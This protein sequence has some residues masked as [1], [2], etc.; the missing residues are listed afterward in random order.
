MG[1]FVEDPASDI[2]RSAMMP[3]QSSLNASTNFMEKSLGCH[4]GENGVGY[5][6]LKS[7]EADDGLGEVGN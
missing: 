4:P 2:F 1:I 5:R 7:R 6:Q 3:S